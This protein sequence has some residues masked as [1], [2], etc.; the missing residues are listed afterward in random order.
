MLKLFDEIGV[1][2]P[3]QGYFGSPTGL[4][5]LTLKDHY[6]S[7][8]ALALGIAAPADLITVWDRARN[9]L[10]YSWFSYD[11]NS[12]APLQ[13]FVALEL[14]LRMRLGD[15]AKGS[16]GMQGLLEKAVSDGIV[17]DPYKRPPTLAAMAGKMRN[18]WG[19]GTPNVADPNLAV[20][21]FEFCKGLISA[22]YP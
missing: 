12:V 9:T 4:G 22:L 2:D 13:A 21:T 15:R 16:P 17:I 5:P 1:P 7:I 3:I 6:L 14:G 10:L 11:L 19:H 18:H 20:Q 8:E